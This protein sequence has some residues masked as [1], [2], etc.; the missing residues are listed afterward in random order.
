MAHLFGTIAA[1]QD[2]HRFTIIFSSLSIDKETGPQAQ[3]YRLYARTIA[4][5]NE[6]DH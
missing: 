2:Y 1:S 6:E 3:R 4:A 5:R